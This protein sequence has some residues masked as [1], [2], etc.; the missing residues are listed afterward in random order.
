MDTVR[1]FRGLD[2][3]GIQAYLAKCDAPFKTSP[4]YSTETEESFVDV[5]LRKSVYR[6]IV[7]PNLFALVEDLMT[8]INEGDDEYQYVMWKNGSDITHIKYDEG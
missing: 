8:A 3:G 4:L 7:D 2:V 1:S 5:S 6:T